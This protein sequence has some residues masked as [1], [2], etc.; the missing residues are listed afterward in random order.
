MT[1]RKADVNPT[2]PSQAKKNIFSWTDSEIQ[3]LLETTKDFKA[4]QEYEGVDWNTIR[5]R[6]DKIK[7]AFINSYPSTDGQD[8]PHVGDI[9]D[10]FTKERIMLK[11]K[12]IRLGF[13]K[14][15]DPGKTF[16]MAVVVIQRHRTSSCMQMTYCTLYILFKMSLC[17]VTS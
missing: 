5:T 10:T 16:C 15:L 2:D 11:L 13:K 12:A 7:D 8:Y 14:A 4:K 1:I 9:N 17:N 3:L 6:F